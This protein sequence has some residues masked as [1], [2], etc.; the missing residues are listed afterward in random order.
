MNGFKIDKINSYLILFGKF[1]LA[2]YYRYEI[3][4]KLQDLRKN[5]LND[6]EINPVYD[7]YERN[8]GQVTTAYNYEFIRINYIIL[9]YKN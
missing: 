5:I 8:Y 1:P 3:G 4:Q 6:Y 9:N 7:Y 2:K